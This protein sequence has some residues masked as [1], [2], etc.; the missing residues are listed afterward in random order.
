MTE[1][2]DWS[3]RARV[4]LSKALLD[5]L[6]GGFD[7]GLDLYT[8]YI[9]TTTLI[10]SDL[11]FAGL[12]R[13]GLAN[14]T[15]IAENQYV[16]RNPAAEPAH[17]SILSEADV[18]RAGAMTDCLVVLFVY[19]P[20]TSEGLFPDRVDNNFWLNTVLESD[21]KFW[22]WHDSR[23][24]HI[25]RAEN[26]PEKRVRAFLAT[27]G[28]ARQL[29]ELDVDRL[30][31]FEARAHVWFSET[32]GPAETACVSV[33]SFGGDYLAAIDHLLGRKNDDNVDVVDDDGEDEILQL[34]DFY[35]RDRSLLH[36]RWAKQAG[37]CVALLA[38]TRREGRGSSLASCHSNKKGRLPVGMRFSCLAIASDMSS[39]DSRR[40]FAD[41]ATPEAAVVCFY[42]QD[43][44]CL[45]Q[46]PWR[47]LALAKHLDTRGLAQKLLNRTDL[48]E[49]PKKLPD[50]VVREAEKK[51]DERLE[52]ERNKK[53]PKGEGRRP[54]YNL[55]KRCRCEACKSAKYVKNMAKAGPDKLCTTPYTVSEL[56]GLLG[57]LDDAAKSTIAQMV[58]LS[59][60]AMDIESRTFE[61]DLEGPRPGHL[62]EYPEIG[63]PIL[64]GHV[65][66]AQRPIMIGHTDALTRRRGE[67]WHDTVKDDSP[68][69]VYA[70]FAR[71]WLKVTKLREDAAKEKAVLAEKMMDLSSRYSQ[72]YIAFS[73]AWI[74]TSLIE[75]EHHHAGR[76]EEL[77]RLKE[78][79]RLDEDSYNSLLEAAFNSY[80]K[81]DEW[82]MPTLG[83]IG[84][85]FR[86]TLPGL[87]QTRLGNLIRRYV[88]FNFYG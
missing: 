12:S 23:P 67:K 10:D 66:K 3:R 84:T 6:A 35:L 34:Q 51:R 65:F 86:N 72:A 73:N 24:R 88:V 17:W 59:V 83:Q 50:A 5:A 77:K 48:S 4:C 87:L 61:V 45:M 41:H 38:Y 20:A 27:S 18:N 68:Q 82:S 63:G 7:N 8:R 55:K 37:S 75:R 85:A 53:R 49:V 47:S 11:C 43:Y 14:R 33:S 29:Y 21:K 15:L 25:Q 58:Q 28:R 70:L 57:V 76:A 44:V 64:E 32:P 46:D 39:D 16:N 69:A 19:D 52:K 74:E 1:A 54:K 22:L 40:D 62:V 78:E 13:F 26:G 60:A 9:D 81:S 56:L 80:F 79:D 2:V 71:Y 31:D 42:G 30:A 36:K